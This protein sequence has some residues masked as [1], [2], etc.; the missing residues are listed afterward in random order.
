MMADVNESST[1]IFRT[2]ISCIS[3]FRFL[4]PPNKKAQRRKAYILVSQPPTMSRPHSRERETQM[5]AVSCHDSGTELGLRNP[6][7]PPG[8]GHVMHEETSGQLTRQLRNVVPDPNSVEHVFNVSIGPLPIE[9]VQ[10]RSWSARALM[11]IVLVGSFVGALLYFVRSSVRASKKSKFIALTRTAG[12]CKRTLTPTVSGTFSLDA[13]GR[14]SSDPEYNPTRSLMRVEF[15][16]FP[17]KEYQEA[18]QAAAAR[19]DKLAKRSIMENVLFALTWKYEF[20]SAKEGSVVFS[21]AADAGAIFD[22]KTIYVGTVGCPS[23]NYPDAAH[24]LTWDYLATK[25]GLRY[26]YHVEQQEDAGKTTVSWRREALDACWVGASGITMEDLFGFYLTN[27][28]VVDSELNFEIDWFSAS[29]ASAINARVLDDPFFMNE[30]SRDLFN[31]PR[32]SDNASNPPDDEYAYGYYSSFNDNAWEYD[33]E[34]TWAS[35]I[36]WTMNDDWGSTS[37]DYYP[38]YYTYQDV[39]YMNASDWYCP[40]HLPPEFLAAKSSGDVRFF[41][42]D[43]VPGMD[44]IA[45]TFTDQHGWV[46]S[47]VLGNIHV[48]PFI[49]TW[50]DACNYCE[51]TLIPE[52][53]SCDFAP[54]DSFNPDFVGGFFVKPV[55]QG[56]FVAHPYYDRDDYWRL[57]DKDYRTLSS[58]SRKTSWSLQVSTP[59]TIEYDT[60][61][62]AACTLDYETSFI[63]FNAYERDGNAISMN[64]DGHTAH[65]NEWHCTN[66]WSNQAAHALR[67]VATNDKS[68]TTL[69]ENYFECKY[70]AS[71]RWITALGVGL[72]NARTF[73]LVVSFFLTAVVLEA[74][75]KYKRNWLAH[76]VLVTEDD[77]QTH[78]LLEAYKAKYRKVHRPRSADLEAD[79]GDIDQRR[80]VTT[81]R[82]CTPQDVSVVAK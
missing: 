30:L 74:V 13:D 42:D 8:G 31:F 59:S 53:S 76:G 15:N 24:D 4:Q 61:A 48:Y 49:Q 19:V 62:T 44:P 18:M 68:P 57:T 32:H 81:P 70:K 77:M 78:S 16:D 73:F 52:F 14:W 25:D 2:A 34:S 67:S 36:E 58:L 12:D 17:T 80:T 21:F 10:L 72:S 1:N 43:R 26:E 65:P 39:S 55:E 54:S 38:Y 75:A 9:I 11:R 6:T 40:H 64:A 71:Q 51:S 29:V 69:F 23:A 5:I 46:C 63:A 82:I 56:P 79:D 37:T 20:S 7:L 66:I 41:T 33:A 45:C 50:L 3:P 60:V 27:A 35:F 28:I 47:V 22:A